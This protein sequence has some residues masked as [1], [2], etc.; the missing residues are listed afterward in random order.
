M[1]MKF[2]NK[3]I[4]V[5]DDW[6]AIRLVVE[7]PKFGIGDVVEVY[8]YFGANNYELKILFRNMPQSIM[9]KYWY[10]M[11]C[12]LKILKNNNNELKLI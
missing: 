6:G 10:S 2:E 5:D 11:S 1:L 3:E 8:D 7:H 12:G 4:E 9:S